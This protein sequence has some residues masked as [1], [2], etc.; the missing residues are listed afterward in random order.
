MLES[1]F[2]TQLIKDIEALLPGA[3]VFHLNPVMD[4]R[5]IPDLIVHY[6]GRCGFLEGK[7]HGNSSKRPGQDYYISKLSKEGFA[8][9]IDQENKQ[10]VLDALQRALRNS[11]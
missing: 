4:G 3:M 2:K 1:K 9:F 5:G 7:Q 10:E 8:A 11:S 6:Q